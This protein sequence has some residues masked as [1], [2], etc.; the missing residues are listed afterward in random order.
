MNEIVRLHG[1]PI[2]EVSNRDPRFTSRF[3][4]ELQSA[5]GTRLNFSTAFHPQTD[6]QSEIVIQV[7]EDMLRGSALDFSGSWDKYIPL[8][9][10]AYNNSYQSSS[11]MDPYEALYGKRC[12]TL[13]CWT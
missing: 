9:E 2:S 10:F 5:F 6:G 8:M 1:I 7:L 12:R 4:K 3:W 11:C 13:V